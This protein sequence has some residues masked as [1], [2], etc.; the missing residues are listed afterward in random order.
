LKSS[1]LKKIILIGASTR[2]RS[3]EIQK[4]V[5]SLPILKNASIIVA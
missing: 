5:S 2:G 1:K 3:G 4:I